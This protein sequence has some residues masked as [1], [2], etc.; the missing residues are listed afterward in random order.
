[1]EVNK[2]ERA[3]DFAS[4]GELV[5]DL[6]VGRE[7]SEGDSEEKFDFGEIPL[8]QNVS[9]ELQELLTSF[10]TRELD[11]VRTGKRDIEPYDMSNMNRD[12]P[13]VQHVSLNEFPYSE[14]VSDLTG[15]NEFS[16][17]TYEEPRPDIQAIRLDDGRDNLLIGFR[18]YTNRQVVRPSRKLRVLLRGNEYSRFD[19]ELV[20]LPAKI[21]AVYFEDS[22][23][24][25]K[26][27]PFENSFDYLQH[28]KELSENVLDEIESSSLKI[29]NMDEF[30]DWVNN[31][32]RK[33]RKMCQISEFGI[34][35][36]LDVPTALEIINTHG[37]GIDISSSTTGT[38]VL[39]IPDGNKVWDIIKLLNNDHLV[40]PINSEEFQAT[41]GKRRPP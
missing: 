9:D 35:N 2:L 3:Q 14:S 17:T 25:F 16:E 32:R 36:E 20:T 4:S 28:F 26:Q 5:R 41:G 18:E 24:I 38:P 13:P 10:I 22:F 39:S 1:M 21:D 31:D 34:V 29:E 33:I 8:H 7:Q 27:K 30:R 12:D 37:L 15:G 23:I 40:S 19:R 6:I 11:N